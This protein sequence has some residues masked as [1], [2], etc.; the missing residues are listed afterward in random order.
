MLADGRGKIFSRSTWDVLWNFMPTL[1]AVGVNPCPVRGLGP[2]LHTRNL[3]PFPRPVV[4]PD[5]LTQIS[6]RGRGWIKHII[7]S[8]LHLILSSNR[9]PPH[10]ES[11][12]EV[13]RETFT[14]RASTRSPPSTISRFQVKPRGHS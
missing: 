10:Q 2:F 9:G 7:Q 3:Q 5:M 13:T 12:L 11:N 14:S 1:S 4:K 8:I 6:T